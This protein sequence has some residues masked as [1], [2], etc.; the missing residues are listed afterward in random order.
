MAY[1]KV[2]YNDKPAK[3]EV[4][5]KKHK[6]FRSLPI[7]KK[8]LE[9]GLR[10]P[11]IY[12]VKNKGGSIYKITEW[13]EGNTI[14]DEME[15]N[16]D[17]IEQICV[18]LARYISEFR[19]AGRMSPVDNHFKNFIWNSGSVVYVDLKKLLYETY[20]EHIMRMSKL[21]LKNCRGEYKRRKVLAFLNGYAKHG[22]VRDVIEECDK[23]RWLWGNESMNPIILEMLEYK[24]V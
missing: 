22:N 19:D 3:L 21:C 12:D 18:D 13:V 17:S 20:D 14:H 24:E 5:N 7:H 15:N 11:K 1:K 2:T 16:P 6:L 8:A 9:L 10:V 23:R 4:F